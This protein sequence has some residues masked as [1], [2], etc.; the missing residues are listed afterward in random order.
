MSKRCRKLRRLVGKVQVARTAAVDGISVLMVDR[1]ACN[2]QEWEG[3]SGHWRRSSCV[4]EVAL[5]DSHDAVE[6]AE[7]VD[8]D[9]QEA[10]EACLRH[11]E[12]VQWSWAFLDRRDARASPE[13]LWGGTAVDSWHAREMAA[14]AVEADAVCSNRALELGALGH[15]G[16][17]QPLG[18]APGEVGDGEGLIL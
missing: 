17:A 18:V 14:V 6:V 9:E 8:G 15:D 5:Q 11:P 2:L 3:G 4:E 16:R 12:H 7:P 1:V 13:H 10:R